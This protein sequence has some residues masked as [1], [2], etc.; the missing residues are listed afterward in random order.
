MYFSWMSSHNIR[1]FHLFNHTQL[2]VSLYHG[3]QPFHGLLPS[4]FIL[5]TTRSP[6]HR[7][8]S[9]LW[10]AQTLVSP[11]RGSLPLW[12]SRLSSS[13]Q[14]CPWSS[15]H[16][17]QCFSKSPAPTFNLGA[18]CL[19]QASRD[20]EPTRAGAQG[21]LSHTEPPVTT[22]LAQAQARWAITR[23]T[24]VLGFLWQL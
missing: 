21:A 7:S 11:H 4:F 1:T 17:N 10:L 5:V 9:P 24:S 13:S 8:A 2:L 22:L 3:G 15:P 18:Y 19:L 14:L 6:S 20:W 23:G 16:S 12:A